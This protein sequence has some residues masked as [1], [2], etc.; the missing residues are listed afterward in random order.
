MSALAAGSP[1]PDVDLAHLLTSFATQ[2]GPRDSGPA[3][4][5]AKAPL[6]VGT[7]GPSSEEVKQPEDSADSPKSSGTGDTDKK[8]DVPEDE[9]KHLKRMKRNRES[10]AL[11]RR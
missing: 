5:E 4:E 10:A 1:P 3:Q 7:S 2:P 11:S 6:S 9:E 8:E